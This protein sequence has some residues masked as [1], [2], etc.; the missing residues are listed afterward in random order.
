M[1]KYR[2]ALFG[3]DKNLLMVNF[4]GAFCWSHV[5]LFFHNIFTPTLLVSQGSD[6]YLNCHM[7]TLW[8]KE[9]RSHTKRKNMNTYHVHLRK[10]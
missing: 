6:L 2:K 7:A 1:W 9:N 3:C 4:K 10:V 5:F 8:Q